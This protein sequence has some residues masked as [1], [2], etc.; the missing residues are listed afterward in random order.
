MS[1]SLDQLCI[2]TIRALAMDS[3]MAEGFGFT[4]DAIAAR[5]S[6]NLERG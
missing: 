5:V 6:V 3:V 2:D 4:A 1:A